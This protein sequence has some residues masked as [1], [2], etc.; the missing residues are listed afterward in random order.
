MEGKG[1]NMD[2]NEFENNN[3][4][5]NEYDS[6]LAGDIAFIIFKIVVYTLGLFMK[7]LI[8]IFFVVIYAALYMF[9]RSM[10]FKK[11]IRKIFSK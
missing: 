7:L 9:V 3:I 8:L 10:P 5:D 2:N 4:E 1:Q 6:S 11:T